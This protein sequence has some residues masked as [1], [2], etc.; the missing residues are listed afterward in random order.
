M[1]IKGHLASEEESEAEERLD[2]EFNRTLRDRDQAPPH[3]RRVVVIRPPEGFELGTAVAP[4]GDVEGDL[5]RLTD[6]GFELVKAL[7][8]GRDAVAPDSP[9][10]EWI[11]SLRTAP[12]PFPVLADSLTALLDAT[13][14]EPPA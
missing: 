5:A 3:Y 1:L 12:G 8:R 7:P 6:V 14:P 13:A 11:A 4:P 2:A 9:L 10:R